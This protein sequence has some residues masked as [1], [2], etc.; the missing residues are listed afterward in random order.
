MSQEVPKETALPTL[1]V[2]EDEPRASVSDAEVTTTDNENGDEVVTMLDVLEE[3]EDLE[4]NADAG[5]RSF[6]VRSLIK[7]SPF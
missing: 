2:A 6:C 5:N 1:P 3:Q 7:V 4:E